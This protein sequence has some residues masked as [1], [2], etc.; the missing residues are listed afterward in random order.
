LKRLETHVGIRGA[1]FQH[2]LTRA[3]IER[4]PKCLEEACFSYEEV[5]RQIDDPECGLLDLRSSL[6]NLRSLAIGPS[7]TAED[8]GLRLASI[9]EVLSPRFEE[10][11]S[12]L[13]STLTNLSVT[14]RILLMGDSYDFSLLPKTLVDLTLGVADRICLDFLFGLP[15]LRT[16]TMPA[17]QFAVFG[18]SVQEKPLMTHLKLKSCSKISWLNSANKPRLPSSESVFLGLFPNLQSLSLG[19]V[20]E[21]EWKTLP[22][23]SSLQ[24][25][26]LCADLCD[27]FPFPPNLTKLKFLPR[28]MPKR[29]TNLKIELPPSLTYLRLHSTIP[30]SAIAQFPDGI[31]SLHISWFISEQLD[32]FRQLP[33]KLLHL[34]SLDT[35]NRLDFLLNLQDFF[36]RL[37]QSLITYQ[38]G[39]DRF[40]LKNKTGISRQFAVFNDD[41]SALDA[42]IQYPK[43][44]NDV[45]TLNSAKDAFK[46]GSTRVLDWYAAQPQ[47]LRSFLNYIGSKHELIDDLFQKDA[48]FML[49]WLDRYQFKLETKSLLLNAIKH[50]AIDCME[51]MKRKGYNLS[52]AIL[53]DGAT[54]VTHAILL[55]RRKSLL[56]LLEQQISDVSWQS[57][58]HKSFIQDTTRYFTLAHSVGISVPQNS[59]ELILS[60]LSHGIPRSL[61][62]ILQAMVTCGLNAQD[63]SMK[64]VF[65][66]CMAQYLLVDAVDLYPTNWCLDICNWFHSNQ[67]DVLQ[68]FHTTKGES[69]DIQDIAKQ[70]DSSDLQEWLE[71]I[72]TSKD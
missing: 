31:T 32:V 11:I 71:C 58:V 56:W 59:I 16:L 62:R 54:P 20:P 19:I 3:E 65:E 70:C 52:G 2:Q 9:P 37:P 24:K 14:F 25:W 21:I 63:S 49:D 55:N 27:N 68:P 57:I 45:L 8:I 28:Y 10:F 6:P 33:R 5:W 29:F 4:L 36:P 17:V 38:S 12:F 66:A 40:Y 39:Q 18:D 53:S 22:C 43:L 15:N 69:K 13:P 34:Q 67:I 26:R 47:F 44:F 41:P 23:W 30:A 1:K 61:S 35:M 46:H 72:S 42:M 51:W 48:S 64:R 7:L 50:D 60:A